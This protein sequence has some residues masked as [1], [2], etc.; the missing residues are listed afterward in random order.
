MKFRPLLSS[1][2]FGLVFALAGTALAAGPAH[3][4]ATDRARVTFHAD[5]PMQAIDATSTEGAFTYDAQTGD[6]SATVPVASFKFQNAQMETNFQT[7][8]VAVNEPGPKNA[9]GEPNF[10][11]KFTTLTGKLE[12]PI[13]VSKEGSHEVALKG[14]LSF[15]GI[16]KDVVVKGTVTV[17][18]TDLVVAAKLDV[19]PKEYNVPLPKLGDKEIGATVSVVVDATLSAKP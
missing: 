13:D 4:F 11:N 2:A 12:K 3:Q 18:G 5:T 19:A 6:F 1:A 16:T 8:H 7:G 9:K 15:H 14:K 10:P 17:K